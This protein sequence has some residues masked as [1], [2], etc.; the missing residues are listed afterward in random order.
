MDEE[1]KEQDIKLDVLDSNIEDT[2]PI[3]KAYTEYETDDIDSYITQEEIDRLKEKYPHS[4]FGFFMHV[5]DPY[6]Y[7]SYTTRELKELNEERKQIETRT[8]KTITDEEFLIIMLKKFVIRPNN[9]EK[10]LKEESLPAGIP[11]LLYDLV[12]HI[13]G[14]SEVDPVIL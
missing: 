14:F 10:R 8:G 1:R 3:S 13:S 6:L 12:N 11:T 7:R 5:N 4:K 9:I 2:E